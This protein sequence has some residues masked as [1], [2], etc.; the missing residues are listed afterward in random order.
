VNSLHPELVPTRS[1]DA[2]FALVP[3]LPHIFNRSRFLLRM[4]LPPFHPD[5]PNIAI[6][7]A[8]CAAT[9]RYVGDV[10]NGPVNQDPIKPRSKVD[11]PRTIT[12]FVARHAALGKL[13]IENNLAE[14]KN[15]YE[16]AQAL[17]IMMHH[18]HVEG[19]LLEGWLT[20]GCLNRLLNPLGIMHER[21]S[22][23]LRPAMGLLL[24]PPKDIIEKQERRN[25]LWCAVILDIRMESIGNWSGS[26]SVDDIVSFRDMVGCRVRVQLIDHVIKGCTSAVNHRVF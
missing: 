4:T 15:I 24:P 8:I 20:T 6:L 22:T 16:T 25:L 10:Y 5:F 1:V 12:S 14:V 2:F 9:G 26:I 17:C 19:F 3:V 7:H 21:Y 18:H 11:N 13:A 23:D